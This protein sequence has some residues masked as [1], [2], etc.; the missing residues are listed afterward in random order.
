MTRSFRFPRCTVFGSLVLGL[1]FAGLV[2]AGLAAV[3]YAATEENLRAFASQDGK[4]ALVRQLL[5]QQVNPNAPEPS[6]GQTAV[7]KAA[8]GTLGKPAVKNLEAL[9][10]AGG[11]PNGQDR[12]GNTPLH[13]ASPGLDV[14][15]DHVTPIR[16]LLQHHADPNLANAQGRTPLHVAEDTPVFR[17]LL[18]AG[19]KPEMVDREGLTALQRFVRSGTNNGEIVTLLVQAGADPDRK[20]PR[21]DAPLHAAIKEGGS[22][23]N[24]AVVT[25]LL[26]G[27]ADPCVQDDK[28]ATPYHLS[29][30]MQRIHRAL[31]RAG[32]D[33]ASHAGDSGCKWLFEDDSK[34]AYEES[35]GSDDSSEMTYGNALQALEERVEEER[36]A[37]EAR[38][39]AEERRV[40]EERQAA[41]ARRRAAA[42]RAE[43]RAARRA[44][45][46]AAEQEKITNFAIQLN[47]A[48]AAQQRREEHRR[49][50]AEQ[51][52]LAAE[53]QRRAREEEQ[54][55]A[56]EEEHRRA[57]ARAFAEEAAR[58]EQ[59]RREE[60]QQQTYDPCPSCTAIK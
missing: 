59:Q 29:S 12:E 31:A 25:A 54:R 38:R 37:E 55:R 6:T 44:A 58:L 23:G 28:G 16:V 60:Q 52:R 1:V 45:E 14:F 42:R 3:K 46:K 41:E 49:L 20:D 35:E 2:P 30:G 8:E 39:L 18:A 48:F 53:Q 5:A 21:G 26:A 24:A 11:D 9:L 7:H 33:D 56:H 43:E 22:H 19:A 40:A 10:Q 27:G 32:G 34:M 51:Q 47:Q 15:G 4:H 57:A 36:R 13:F 17:A 50:A